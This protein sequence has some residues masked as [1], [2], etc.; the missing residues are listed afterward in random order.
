MAAENHGFGKAPL[1]EI[2]DVVDHP[3]R[4]SAGSSTATAFA[5]SEPKGKFQGIE[6]TRGAPPPNFY[7]HDSGQ[8][9]YEL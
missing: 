7:V 2:F 5:W 1:T 8:S 3:T 9:I 6:W 4:Q